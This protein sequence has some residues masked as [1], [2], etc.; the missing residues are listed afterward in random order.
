MK[1]IYAL[2][3]VL[4]LAAVSMSAQTR[5]QLNNTAPGGGY[6]ASF[7]ILPPLTP[8][9]GTVELRFPSTSGTALIEDN[10]GMS[11]MT[12]ISLEGKLQL[13][14]NPLGDVTYNY[15][16][17]FGADP[18]GGTGDL[19]GMR[20]ISN[21]A[22][23]QILEL[24]AGND[25]G[26]EI[27]LTT[28][29]NDGVEI[30]GF[31]ALHTGNTSDKSLTF[32]GLTA[33]TSFTSNGTTTLGNNIDD[34]VTITGAL[35]GQYP[36][37]FEGSTANGFE[38]RLSIADPTADRTIT[39][40]DA[41][42]TIMVANS[43]GDLSVARDLSVGR[44]LTVTGTS[45]FTGAVNVDGGLTIQHNPTNDSATYTLGLRF[46]NDPYGGGSDLAGL[47]MYNRNNTEDMIMEFYTNNDGSDKINFSVNNGTY[48]VTIN[49]YPII[50][51]N[52]ASTLLGGSSW[53][54]GGN[55][56]GSVQ[57]LGSNDNYAIAFETNNT[58]RMRLDTDGD[59]GIGTTNP[60]APL[61]VARATSNGT[62]Y[63]MLMNSA[64]ANNLGSAVQISFSNDVGATKT[65]PNAFIRSENTGGANNA[66][67]L[68]FGTYD[69][70]AVTTKM[71]IDPDGVVGVSNKLVVGA[72]ATTVPMELRASGALGVG[73]NYRNTDA[74]VF[75]VRNTGSTTTSNAAVAISTNNST[76]GDPILSWDIE[77]VGGWSMGIDNSD[78][79]KLKI[80]D[81]WDFDVASGNTLMTLDMTSN[82]VSM[83]EMRLLE[84][85]A[86]GTNFTAFKAQAQSGDIT[87]TLPAADG[88]S[89][90]VMSTNGSGT[91]S[92]ASA[93][94]ASSQ[95]TYT[96]TAI[97]GLSYSSNNINLSAFTGTYEKIAVPAPA[98]PS[99]VTLPAGTDGQVMY[100]RFA[101]T[102]GTGTVTIN[103]DGGTATAMVY[104]GAGSDV[105]VAHM[106]Y[107]T[108]EKWVV[109]SA[110]Y[111][112]N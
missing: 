36:L 63:V 28:V 102:A 53:L 80:I 32:D 78:D 87:Y 22:D 30:N 68:S 7:I 91:L 15:G 12:N 72:T 65:L 79:D 51:T 97:T 27:R 111:F 25:A 34:N 112:N 92:W 54:V 8:T 18:Y 73:E 11:S 21:G 19:S 67:T 104:D 50:T 60:D 37:Y 45:N 44:N 2:A 88:S 9:T 33:S 40:P 49:N 100:V 98:A 86:S 106:L 84:P 16:L 47:R 77:T 24:F 55:T 43:S 109:L 81:T 3:A 107:T 26:D 38:T 62:T 93:L 10:S 23:N 42:G 4:L 95:S 57:R 39:L 5:L 20:L 101:F 75:N 17:N 64:P 110:Q 108:T 48:G 82:S 56:V 71:S 89:G 99:T 90:Q 85:S 74:A 76:G 69:G 35:Q 94:T 31:T 29:S 96:A 13:K 1:N 61:H 66:A 46:Q 59:L 6:G 41:D 70:T 103:N 58:E 83:M 14:P 52:N 105:I